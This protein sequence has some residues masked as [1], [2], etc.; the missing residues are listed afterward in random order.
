MESTVRDSLR[1]L[2][3]RYGH[4]LGEDPS[5][6]EAMLRDLCGQHKREIFI[7]VSA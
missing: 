6:C 4:A 7:L 2:I 5:R 3:V 1:A